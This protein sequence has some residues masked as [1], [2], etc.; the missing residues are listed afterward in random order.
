MESHSKN[1]LKSFDIDGRVL[2]YICRYKHSDLGPIHWTEFYEGTIKVKRKKYILFGET[3]EIEEPKL[4]FK[5]TENCDCPSR[6]RGLLREKIILELEKFDK[7][8]N[9]KDN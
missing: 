7:N 2:Q 1:K 9:L 4:I 5:I 3:L 8:N 6:S